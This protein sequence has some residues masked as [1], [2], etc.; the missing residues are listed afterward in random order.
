MFTWTGA[1]VDISPNVHKMLGSLGPKLYFF[2]LSRHEET[3][4]DY[5]NSRGADF[6][7]KVQAIRRALSKYL[8]YFEANPDIIKEEG[9]PLSK[10]QMDTDN[11]V[12]LA[13]GIIIRVGIL[14]AHLRAIVPTWETK[15]TQ[16]SDYA[17]AFANIE[18]P[19]R[20]ITQLRNLARGHALSQGRT[21]FTM[22]NI[23]VVIHTAL[24]TASMSR[25]RIFELL[26]EK[27]GRLTT[28]NIVE[29][30]NTSKPTALRTM[31]EL[32]ATELVDMREENPGQYNSPKEI[33]LKDKFMWF[34]T[35]QFKYLKEKA[36]KV[37]G[38]RCKE[39]PTP[40]GGVVPPLHD[41]IITRM[42]LLLQRQRQVNGPLLGGRN[43]LHQ[44]INME[45][46]PPTLEFPPKCYYCIV[47]GFNNKDRY[48]E[49]VIRCH[50]GLTAYPGPADLERHNLAP[51]GMY[52]ENPR[53]A[54][55]NFEEENS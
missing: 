28:D 6:A 40:E 36:T 53:P 55:I 46:S 18:D 5:H 17:Y 51:Q 27:K 20:A 31:T 1:C 23:P 32:K 37:E 41:C 12:K 39:K 29:F 45:A 4:D 8:E 47:G 22:D 50:K 33:I 43:S 21:Y 16:G 52:W 11:D 2:R 44:Y 48:E 34:L 49:H 38:F 14:L 54:G 25:V 10:I 13:D 35:D 3:E 24:S 42:V 9:N 30:L 26:V 7:K 19:S 15:D